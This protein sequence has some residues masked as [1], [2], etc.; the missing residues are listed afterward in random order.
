MSFQDIVGHARQISLLRESLRHGNLAPAYL[1]S[2]PEGVGKRRAALEFGRAVL[3][4]SMPEEVCGRC[5][6]CLQIERGGHPDFVLVAVEEGKRLLRKEQVAEMQKFLALTPAWGSWKFALVDDAESMTVNSANAMLKTLEEPPAGTLIVLVSS[7]SGALPPTVISRC[8]KVG[9]G[10]LSDPEVEQVLLN[11]GVA[12]EEAAVA[13]SL[14]EGCPGSVAALEG[15]VW[16]KSSAVLE[17]VAKAVEA[18]DKGALL[19]VVEKGVAGD[20]RGV[21]LTVKMLLGK[22]RRE[23]RRRLG[24]EGG[25]EPARWAVLREAD[26]N[27]LH[28]LAARLVEASRLLAGNV[29]AKLILG[30][31]F[32]EWADESGKRSA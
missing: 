8:R 15:E 6:S 14:S 5:R 22:V 25:A 31:L 24:L 27:E 9:F 28:R 1:F 19:T 23:I 3:C 29:N 30:T 12:V 11:R 2:G 10:S 4:P 7:N 20:R 17:K 16:K 13:A 26:D 32:V 18:G 21:D